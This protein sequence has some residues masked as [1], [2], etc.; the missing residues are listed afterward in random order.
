MNKLMASADTYGNTLVELG[1]KNPDIFAVDADLMK[2]SGSRVF[3][4]AFP[5]R[6]I[7]V[8]VAEQN[9][10]SLA[11]GIAAMGR[12]PF[13]STMSNFISQRACDQVVISAAYTKFNVKLVGSFA[14]LSQEK[15]GGTH[16]GV[17][18]IAVMRCIPNMT[19]FVASDQR[20]LKDIMIASTEIEGPVYIRMARYLPGD[21]FGNSYNFKPGKG[22]Q[23]CNG[24]DITLISTGI[25]SM[26][27]LESLNELKK[28]NISCRMV[29]LPSLKPTDKDIILKCARETRAIITLEDHSIYGGLGG[30]VSEIVAAEHPKTVVKIGMEDTF[31]L[32]APLEYQL[33]YF[34]IDTENI[35]KRAEEILSK[36]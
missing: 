28:K 26:V 20:E 14:G 25:S 6:H 5:D 12:I 30:L 35:V 31:G 29:H 4:D 22:Y 27:A 3:K 23:V 8:G 34:G 7:N 19:V 2:A 21:L 9:L 15:N 11:A 1:T 17:M 24:T 16:I 32:T 33:K 18:D 10:V 13:A 36:I